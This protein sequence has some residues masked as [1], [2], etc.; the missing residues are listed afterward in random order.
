MINQ[1]KKRGYT[2][3]N[4]IRLRSKMPSFGECGWDYLLVVLNR[5]ESRVQIGQH[6]ECYLYNFPI[7]S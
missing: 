4:E 1:I 5:S 3:R 7:N 6:P 2:L